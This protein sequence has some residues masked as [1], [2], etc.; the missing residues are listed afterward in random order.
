MNKKNKADCTKALMA[1][2]S[3]NK[4]SLP[5]RDEVSP[6]RSLVS[7]IM[8]QQTRVSY[9]MNYFARFMTRFPTIQDL[10][11]ATEEEVLSYWQGLGYYSRA[12]NLHKAA[13]MVVEL[14]AFPSTYKELQKLPG[15]G[16]YVAG[17]IASIAF[18][19]D[20]PAVDGNHH[21]ILSRLFCSNGSRKEMWDLAESL[22]P[23]GQAGDFNQALMDLG[24]SICIP[25]V[26]RCDGC[27][28]KSYCKAYLSK[29]VAQYPP[30]KKKKVVPVR[31]RFYVYLLNEKGQAC[32]AM[33]PSKGLYGGLFEFPGFFA[34][35][36]EEL[37]TQWKEEFGSDLSVEKK[38]G[39]IRHTLTHMHIEAQLW[40]CVATP[41]VKSAFYTE[42]RWVFSSNEVPFST[43]SKKIY[44]I[45]Q[46]VV[47]LE[48]FAS[49]TII[50][51]KD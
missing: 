31:K 23:K 3:V 29:T 42:V 22:L 30:K 36:T 1:W 45:P 19:V 21:R 15:V 24:S 10:S 8:L 13:K 39:E 34:E 9:V 20:T 11:K 50:E 2:Y 12:R 18:N 25:K 40:K 37:K 7:E 51:E 33:R 47:Q 43:L 32:V 46:S 16:V 35:N 5:W 38:L 26:P 28:L 48:L 17:A 6:Y 44:D 41:I 27:P 49:D 4:R 14:G